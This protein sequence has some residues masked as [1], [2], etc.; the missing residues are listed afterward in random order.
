MRDI[1]SITTAEGVICVAL[2]YPNFVRSD[3]PKCASIDYH[4]L[5]GEGDKHYCDVLLS[6]GTI[7]RYFN[8]ECI[9]FASRLEE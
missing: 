4:E 3:I 8:V 9:E 5:K 1:K 2:Y 7:R 6:D